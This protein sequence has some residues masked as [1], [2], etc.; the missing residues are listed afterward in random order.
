MNIAD[1][2]VKGAVEFDR[3]DPE[4][5]YIAS[6]LVHHHGWVVENEGFNHDKVWFSRVDL[7]SYIRLSGSQYS[8]LAFLYDPMRWQ[9]NTT[10]D[11]PVL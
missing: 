6:M 8:K 2:V 10:G 1:I 5:A 9:Y 3:E 7:L 4:L 11:E